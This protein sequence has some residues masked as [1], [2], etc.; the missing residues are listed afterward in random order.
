MVI[1]LMF[2]GKSSW[3]VK[4]SPINLYSREYRSNQQLQ[5]NRKALVICDYDKD[6]SKYSIQC[7]RRTEV[8]PSYLLA[9]TRPPLFNKNRS[10]S[11]NRNSE[12]ALN[13]LGEEIDKRFNI[14]KQTRDL[15]DKV[16]LCK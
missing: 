2:E 15:I 8:S 5:K 4:G 6:T 14:K 3:A 16:A 1:K 13:P 10:L 7:P 12:T 11:Q 9:V